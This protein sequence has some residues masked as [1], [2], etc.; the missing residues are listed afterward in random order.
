MSEWK[1]YVNELGNFEFPEFL[2]KTLTGL[3][4]TSLD[5]GTLVC[6]DASKL[7][8]YKEQIKAAH[9][10]R[11]NDI[12]IALQSFDIIE[13]CIC[14]GDEFCSVCGGSRFVANTSINLENIKEH[15]LALSI[16]DPEIKK[17]LE[18]GMEKA[19]EDVVKYKNLQQIHLES[20]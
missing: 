15:G 20:E 16:P 11:W 19:L 6:T 18:K 3:M 5:L 9:K 12:A 7:R 14:K 17:K 13:P 2:Y 8:A 4:K 10:Q 1:K